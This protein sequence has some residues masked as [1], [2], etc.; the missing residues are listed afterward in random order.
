MQEKTG[1]GG[2]RRVNEET[3]EQVRCINRQGNR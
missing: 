3:S 2:S 1:D